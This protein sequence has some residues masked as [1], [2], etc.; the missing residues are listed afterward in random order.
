MKKVTRIVELVI[1]DDQAQLAIDAISLVNSP[2][3]EENWVALNKHKKQNIILAKV[4]EEKRLLVGPALIPNKQI[5]RVDEKTGDEYYVYFS[6]KT[7][8][9]ASELYLIHNNQKSATYEHDERI[10]GVTTVESW[11][12]QDTAMDKARL[13]G[14]K[15]IPKG[16]WMVSMKVDND[17]VWDM[18]KRQEVKG[19][20]IEGYFVDKMSKLSKKTSKPKKL[21]PVDILD[22]L[23]DILD[24][25][26]Y[27]DYPKSASNNADRAIRE[28]E[29]RGNKCAT[30]TGKVRAQQI[31]QRRPIS[32]DTVKRVYS[33]LKRAKAYDTGNYDDCGTISYN[34]W[35]GDVM[36]RWAER[37]IKA[38]NGK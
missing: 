5:Y 4:D 19:Y 11:I 26:S 22:A 33:Y 21:K 2:A 7:V 27:N 10:A 20:S 36:M 6:E 25:A 12:V 16:T 14:Y 32:F 9:R 38:E 24:L 1:D 3:I 17:T 35:G 30:Q 15:N 18:I 34:L 28:N 8:K 31:K 23:A 37:I 29:K 13:Y